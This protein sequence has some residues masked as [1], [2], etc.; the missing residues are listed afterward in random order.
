MVL[1]LRI[2]PGKYSLYLIRMWSFV[3]TGISINCSSWQKCCL[4]ED[5]L[6]LEK[7]FVNICHIV[8]AKKS[9]T[10]KIILTQA[11]LWVYDIKRKIHFFSYKPA[12]YSNTI[13][14][15]AAILRAMDKLGVPFK[16]TGFL[17]PNHWVFIFPVNILNKKCLFLACIRTRKTSDERCCKSWGHRFVIDLLTDMFFQIR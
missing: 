8:M 13:Q 16:S 6:R 7:T 1:L 4:G 2:M 12:I 3:M 11:S 14:S 10:V 9:L 15:L 5:L 17:N